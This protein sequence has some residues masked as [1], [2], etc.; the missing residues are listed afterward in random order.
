[1]PYTRTS[2]N[3]KKMLSDS[4]KKLLKT[5]PFSKVTVSEIIADCGVNRKT[6]YY[7]FQDIYDLLKWTMEEDVVEVLKNYDLLLDYEEVIC[8]V[9]DYVEKNEHM[10]NCVYDSMGRD[11][12]R[13]FFS[14]D[15]ADM[16]TSVI[17]LGEE[18]F[19]R[20]LNE[21]FFMFLSKFYTEALAGILIDYIRDKDKLSREQIVSY[22]SFVI[23]ASLTGILGEGEGQGTVLCPMFWDTEPSPVPHPR[24]DL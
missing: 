17:R 14:K 10:I 7:H 22:V 20:K 19:G 13:R 8:F 24:T 9:L 11:E 2:L 1:M 23:K 15:F 18:K 21:D 16:T 12:M 6:F 4:L 5:K 3:T